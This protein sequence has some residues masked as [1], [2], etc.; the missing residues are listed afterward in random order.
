MAPRG[1]SG[2]RNRMRSRVSKYGVDSLE[3][4]EF[5]ELLLYNVVP[6]KNTNDIAHDLIDIFGSIDKVLEAPEEKLKGAGLSE[7]AAF[8]LA[9]LKTFSRMYS[10]HFAREN[11]PA[12][13]I[14]SKAEMYVRSECSH[15]MKSG[16]DTAN[17]ILVVSIAVSGDIRYAGWFDSVT[18]DDISNVRTVCHAAARNNAYYLMIAHTYGS[19]VPSPTEYECLMTQRYFDALN[20][21]GICLLDRFHV[22]PFSFSSYTRMGA[23]FS[24]AEEYKESM[25]YRLM[26]DT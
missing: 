18:D 4:H 17:K 13:Q 11:M 23:F 15:F 14:V 10:E 19:G 3:D 22:T 20:N 5:L 12:L 26:N 2:H 8:W 9:H 6:R 25:H 7:R 24:S 16:R 1:H 21:L